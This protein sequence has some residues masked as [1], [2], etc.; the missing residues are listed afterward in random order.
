MTQADRH[1]Q[2]DADSSLR[3]PVLVEV[4]RELLAAEYWDFDLEK[5]HGVL[6]VKDVAGRSALQFAFTIPR[7]MR[8]EGRRTLGTV[9]VAFMM[10]I[11]VTFFGSRLGY[12]KTSVGKTF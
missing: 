4:G 3:T 2:L 7:D 9:V 12:S 1:A 8:M 6:D 5:I 10:A 11:V